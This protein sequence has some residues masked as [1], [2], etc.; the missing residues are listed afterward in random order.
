MWINPAVVDV[1]IENSDFISF[2]QK[3]Q[4]NDR[5]FC[6]EWVEL[7][8]LALDILEYKGE[9]TY[10]FAGKRYKSEMDF[11][12][13]R[14]RVKIILVANPGYYVKAICDLAWDVRKGAKEIAS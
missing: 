12:T 6:F 9:I 10:T 5:E 11:F 2:I 1:I 14:W 3:I 7:V 8:R 13:F 4:A